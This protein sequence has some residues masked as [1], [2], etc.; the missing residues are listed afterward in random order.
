MK[1]WKKGFHVFMA[2]LLIVAMLSGNSVGITG[3]PIAQR[4]VAKGKMKLSRSKL[5]MGS[6]DIREIRL[7]NPKQKVKWSISTKKYGYLFVVKGNKNCVCQIFTNHPGRS[8]KFKVTAKVGKKKFVCTVTVKDKETPKDETKDNTSKKQIHYI[9]DRFVEHNQA[10]QEQRVFFAFRTSEQSER[11]AASGYAGI[12]ITNNDGTSVYEKVIPFSESDFSNW[13]TSSQEKMYLCCIRIKDA[14]IIPGTNSN[15]TVE[16]TVELSDGIKFAS[17]QMNTNNLPEKAD[18]Y[19]VGAKVSY[20]SYKLEY[21]S[22]KDVNYRRVSEATEWNAVSWESEPTVYRYGIFKGG[23]EDYKKNYTKYSK[24]ILN[25]TV[26]IKATYC[27]EKGIVRENTED[28]IKDK[29]EEESNSYYI[30]KPT[31]WYVIANDGT[32][33]TLLSEDILENRKFH[34]EK[35]NVYWYNSDIRSWL[36]GYSGDENL[37]KKDYTT[38]NFLARLLDDVPKDQLLTTQVEDTENT[39]YKTKGGKTTEDKVYLLSMEE[40]E[41][42]KEEILYAPNFN[43]KWELHKDELYSEYIEDLKYWLRTRGQY[44][45]ATARV[46]WSRWVNPLNVNKNMDYGK[47]ID[48]V[49][50]DVTDSTMGVRPVIRINIASLQ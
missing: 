14:A 7:K 18:P 37:S 41:Q 45:N 32:S 4:A 35:E 42:L 33:V 9:T 47:K 30:K 34:S 29:V 24:M 40:A 8:G 27:E 13:T 15:G 5:T 11:L 3:S 50:Y 6:D 43:Y 25:N 12:K 44:E 36:N 38:N 23:Y 1:R 46:C 2:L 16:L 28:Y 48:N 39:Y 49:G 10:N 17:Y 22:E 21:L 31:I 19:A 26:Y 20:G